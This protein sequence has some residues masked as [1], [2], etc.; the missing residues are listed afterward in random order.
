MRDDFDEVLWAMTEAHTA[1]GAPLTTGGAPAAFHVMAKPTGAVCNLDCE[2]CF[3]LS[4]EMLYPGSRFRMVVELQETYIRQ[5]LEAHAHVPEVV[6]AWQ[7]GEPT[8]MGLDFFRRSISLQRRYA[9]PGQRILNTLQTNG[10]LLDDDWG[11]FLKENE[12]LV[13]ISVDGPREMHDAYRVDKGG[14]PTF[15]RVMRGLDVL[16]RHR[17]DWNVLTT[18]HAANG[19]HG[20]LV[21]RFLRDDL[22]ATFIQYIPIIERGTPET[23]EIADSGWGSGVHGRPLY[24]QEGT[25]VTHRSVT[26]QQYGRFLID[27]FEEWVRHD[28]GAVYVQM[29][30]TALANWYGEPG[31]MCVHAETCGEQVALEHNGDLYSCDHF[32]EPGYLLGN[33]GD[34][35]MPELVSLPQQQAFGQNK[36]DTLTKFCLDCDVRVVCN[37]GCPKDRFATSPYGEPGQHYLCPG[38]KEFF[39]HVQG[40]MK[41][42]VALLNA[43]RAPAVLMATYAR[44]DA[45]RGRND[46]CTC[47][48]GRKWKRC[49]GSAPTNATT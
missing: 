43:G 14:K 13:G 47:G 17:V 15:D 29:F 18:I 32:V 22:G 34:R 8:L 20:R 48:S 12:F 7:G 21:Y 23:L 33:I 16:K 35:T 10:T 3:F 9:E 28:I 6:V 4:K 2:Y 37:G 25:L 41:A 26:P 1:D 42:M 49:H 5:L 30:D 38:Y 39:H 36:R 11:V 27:V 44:D 40:P 19:D 46:P 45:R 24:V 31:G